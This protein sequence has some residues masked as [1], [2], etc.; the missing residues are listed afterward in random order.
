MTF[1]RYWNFAFHLNSVWKEMKIDKC[2]TTWMQDSSFYLGKCG[3]QTLT[4]ETSKQVLQL[5]WEVDC[6]CQTQRDRLPYKQQ[7]QRAGELLENVR[8]HTSDITWEEQPA[9]FNGPACKIW[10]DLW[11]L[12]Q[13][14]YNILPINTFLN[15]YNLRTL[16]F[17]WI[18][19]PSYR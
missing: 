15:V 5:T 8:A 12:Y 3:P 18:S 16:K 2:R 10:L 4:L 6:S 1:S 19:Y 7:V 11:I 9:P 17:T 14:K 13:K